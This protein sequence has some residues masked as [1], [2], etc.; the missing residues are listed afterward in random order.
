M[1]KHDPLEEAKIDADES[2]KKKKARRPADDERVAL[3]VPEPLAPPPEPPPPALPPLP[4]V[5]GLAKSASGHYR[6]KA[7]KRVSWYGQM[8][9]LAKG[10]EVSL[11]SYGADGMKRLLEQGVEFEPVD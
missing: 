6:V 7:E 5:P 11:R 10:A 8:T 4:D 3:E 1:P 2:G 9:T